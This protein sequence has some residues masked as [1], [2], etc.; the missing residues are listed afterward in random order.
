MDKTAKDESA[1]AKRP[2]E[3][4]AGSLPIS[5]DTKKQKTTEEKAVDSKDAPGFS[6]PSAEHNKQDKKAAKKMIVV[7]YATLAASPE[8]AAAQVAK[9]K[10]REEQ[11]RQALPILHNKFAE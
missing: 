11:K 5:P 2:L 8:T 4:A 3:A 10:F 6:S 7:D 1:R 9:I